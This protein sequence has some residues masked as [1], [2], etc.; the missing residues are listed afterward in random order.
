MDNTTP[1]ETLT[2]ERIAAAM[3][4]GREAVW[5]CIAEWRGKWNG[6]G[7]PEVNAA[8]DRLIAFERAEEAYQIAVANGVEPRLINGGLRAAIKAIE[9]AK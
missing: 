4:K 7:V 3:E 6:E 5:F 8:L 1:Q 2:P 9:E